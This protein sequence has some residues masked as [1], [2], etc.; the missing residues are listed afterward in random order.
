MSRAD[1]LRSVQQVL[2]SYTPLAELLGHKPEAESV[3]EGARIIGDTSR[4]ELNG[5]MPIVILSFTDSEGRAPER[6]DKSWEVEAFI[7]SEDIFEAAEVVDLVEQ[8]C[9]EY[10]LDR[11]LPQPL[12]HLSA[13]PTERVASERNTGY[14]LEF[15]QPLSVRWIEGA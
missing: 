13:G 2:S 6:E 1:V 5:V 11:R 3:D 15:R 10:R 14:V 9:L 12:S 7:Y 8:A 4:L